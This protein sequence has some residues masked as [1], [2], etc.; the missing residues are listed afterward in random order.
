MSYSIEFEQE[1]DGRW[2]TEIPPLLEVMVSGV[3]M[4]EAKY[5][6]EALASSMSPNQL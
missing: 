1:V 2:R 4:K 5:R 3:A 6:V